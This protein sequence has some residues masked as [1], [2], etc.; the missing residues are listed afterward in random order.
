MTRIPDTDYCAFDTLQAGDGACHRLTGAEYNP[1]W[2]G[3]GSDPARV[4]PTGRRRRSARSR[5][6]ECAQSIRTRTGMG[7]SGR[8]NELLQCARRQSVRVG[9][10]RIRGY[11]LCLFRPAEIQRD[12]F[13]EHRWPH[14]TLARIAGCTRVLARARTARDW[15]LYEDQTWHAAACVGSHFLRKTL[16]SECHFETIY[17]SI[18]GLVVPKE[19]IGE[20]RL[21]GGGLY[22]DGTQAR[23][24][25]L[26]LHELRKKKLALGGIG[27]CTHLLRRVVRIANGRKFL[28][29]QP[30]ARRTVACV[31]DRWIRR[32]RAVARLGQRKGA[33]VFAVDGK[34]VLRA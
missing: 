27:L 12:V 2:T 17:D 10:A 8:L 9:R 1:L 22:V 11:P 14:Q 5:A 30:G 28:R 26:V 23:H 25:P 34:D 6:I 13:P 7:A 3:P 16:T 20:L 31:R 21:S 32:I 24:E 15:E 19:R 4:A 18:H 33:R 29:G